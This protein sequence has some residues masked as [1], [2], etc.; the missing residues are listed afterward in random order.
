MIRW[1]IESSIDKDYIFELATLKGWYDDP[2]KVQV[3]K[4]KGIVEDWWVIEPYEEGCS[5]P[6]LVFPPIRKG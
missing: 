5:C 1:Q 2:P 4:I 6:D 3:K